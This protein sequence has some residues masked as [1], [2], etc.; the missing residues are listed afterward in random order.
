MTSF[1]ELLTASD[2]ELVRIFYKTNAGEEKDFIKR[3]NIVA[4]QL[5]LNH[6]TGMRFR[7]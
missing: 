2:D 7:L 3:I 4:A 6:S 5:E 1:T